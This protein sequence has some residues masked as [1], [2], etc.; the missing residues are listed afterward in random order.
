MVLINNSA[1]LASFQSDVFN[2]LIIVLIC[3][4]YCI[5]VIVLIPI[6][7]LPT[8]GNQNI[9]ESSATSYHRCQ[10]VMES[11][12]RLEWV[13]D[14]RNPSHVVSWGQTCRVW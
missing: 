10:V 9:K 11:T 7:F 3:G 13:P 8:L 6:I 5:Q 4:V 1:L 12:Q 14:P 2:L